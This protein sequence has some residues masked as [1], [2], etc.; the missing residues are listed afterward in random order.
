MAQY[1]FVMRSGP[2]VGKVFPLE[3]QEIY[4]GREPTNMIVINDIQ[5]SRRHAKMEL[6]GSAYLVQDLGSTNGT[7][8]NGRRLSG[9]QALNPGDTVELGESIVLAYELVKDLNATMVSTEHHHAPVQEEPTQAPSPA[10]VPAPAPFS[11]PAP[12]PL[13]SGQVPA[14]PVPSSP[15]PA[16]PAAT[17][18]VPMPPESVKPRRKFPVWIIILIIFFV[19]ICACVGFFLVIDQLRL[20]CKVVPFLVP[21]LG[22]TCP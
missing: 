10:P 13:Y 2:V 18:S 9:T 5:V 22:G 15:V 21:L 17:D 11:Q 16:A 1:R 8:V 14:G 3:A 4:I 7:F 20:W 19:I 12:T 6:R